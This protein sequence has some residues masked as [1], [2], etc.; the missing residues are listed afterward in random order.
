MQNE[1]ATKKLLKSNSLSK[2]NSL[3]APPPVGLACHTHVLSSSLPTQW[4]GVELLLLGGGAGRR[5]QEWREAV[6]PAGQRS[7]RA[8][9]R[10]RATPPRWQDRWEAAGAVGG[11]W[12]SGRRWGRWGSRGVISFLAVSS[13][14]SS[15]AGLV[16]GSGAGGAAEPVSSSS[17]GGGVTRREE[18]KGGRARVSWGDSEHRP[19]AGQHI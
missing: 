11:G 8:L 3:Y 16:G 4:R 18:G 5:H 6:G 9:P 2:L 12:S 13:S 19:L 1:I 7:R 17:P 10:R 15:T 14:S